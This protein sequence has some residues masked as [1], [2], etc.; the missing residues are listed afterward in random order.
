MAPSFC[1][2]E[3]HYPRTWLYRSIAAEARH[4]VRLRKRGYAVWQN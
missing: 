3:N 4:A 2:K 1:D